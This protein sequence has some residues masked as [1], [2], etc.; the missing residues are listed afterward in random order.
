MGGFI[1]LRM[2]DL[3]HFAGLIIA[4]VHT[5]AHYVLYNQAYFVV[6]VRQSSLKTATIGPLEN[7]L[8]NG[9]III[10]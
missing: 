8:L 2:V 7:F 5:H 9:I 6:V 1:L 3:Y 4:D 10:A